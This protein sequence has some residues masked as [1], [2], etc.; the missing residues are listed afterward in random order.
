MKAS[1]LHRSERDLQAMR[2]LL[3]LPRVHHQARG[4]SSGN[5]LI[6]CRDF[7]AFA[8]SIDR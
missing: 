8:V 6:G 5:A 2:M 4:A 7:I 1:F 3:L